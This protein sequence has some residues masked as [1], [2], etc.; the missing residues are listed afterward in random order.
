MTKSE[1]LS[2]RGVPEH[3]TLDPKRGTH[4]R[5]G[6]DMRFGTFAL[7]A[8]LTVL[9]FGPVPAAPLDDYCMWIT[10]DAQPSK[11]PP[12][13]CM[14]AK[15]DILTVHTPPVIDPKLEAAAEGGDTHAMQLLAHVHMYRGE[16]DRAVEWLGKAAA[17]NDRDAMTELADIESLGTG[18]E[19]D[20]TTALK[21]YRAAADLG[22]ATAMN[23]MGRLYSEGLG[24]PKDEVEATRW[25]RKAADAGYIPALLTLGERARKAEGQPKN[26]P[27][28]IRWLKRAYAAGGGQMNGLSRAA[29]VDLGEIYDTGDGVKPDRAS[30]FRWTLLA[31]EWGYDP[32]RTRVAQMYRD[33][34]GTARDP[35]QAD[36]WSHSTLAM[37]AAT[38][39]PHEEDFCEWITSG[40]PQTGMTSYYCFKSNM[41]LSFQAPPLDSDT[42][43]KADAGDTHAMLLL[44]NDAF[45]KGSPLAGAEWLRKAAMANDPDAMAEYGFLYERGSFFAQNFDNALFYYHKAADLGSA[46][47]MA[48]I[49]RMYASGEGVTKDDAEATRW[50]VK[51]AAAG[52]EGSMVTAGVRFS[53]GNG[54]PRNGAEA[55]HWLTLAHQHGLHST[56][57][58]VL[59]RLYD[60]GEIVPAD[61]AQ[62]FHWYRLAAQNGDG[63]AARALAQMYRDGRGVE[64][65]ADQ[66]DFW[67]DRARRLAP[68][69]MVGR[70]V[71]ITSPKPH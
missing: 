44:G 22:S 36:Y 41:H 53:D 17:A 38:P 5:S 30:A 58:G 28:A 8:I 16:A 43:K 52:D 39:P 61:P 20:A 60:K 34:I 70:P 14:T 40:A 71:M 15:L 11:S 68:P 55:V 51:A 63:N 13:F 35:E 48:G 29:A 25:F 24:V 21:W 45:Y 65:D 27:E 64:K 37:I 62:A 42:Q 47:G 12:F 18:V 9:A 67:T 57:E 59:A 10:K 19:Q 2:W 6:G 3:V 1:F 23:G 46:H 56:S 50:F 32:A 69:V 4:A 49:A 31:A 26:G 7:C 33:A 66:A 54:V